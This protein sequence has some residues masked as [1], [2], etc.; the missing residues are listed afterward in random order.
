[1]FRCYVIFYNVKHRNRAHKNTKEI[2]VLKNEVMF[3]QIVIRFTYRLNTMN[4]APRMKGD[5]NNLVF[6]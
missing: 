4:M 6:N 3:Q 5:E 1:M 2:L